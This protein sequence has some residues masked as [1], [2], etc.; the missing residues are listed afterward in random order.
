MKK[1]VY[2][3]IAAM[4]ILA[5]TIVYVTSVNGAPK[6]ETKAADWSYGDVFVTSCHHEQSGMMKVK[7]ITLGGIEIPPPAQNSHGLPLVIRTPGGYVYATG[8]IDNSEHAEQYGSWSVTPRRV[9]AEG[10]LGKRYGYVEHV[11][12]ENL[13]RRTCVEDRFGTMLACSGSGRAL[14]IARERGLTYVIFGDRQFGPFD[15]IVGPPKLVEVDGEKVPQF[16]FA[17]QQRKDRVFRVTGDNRE[18][19]PWPETGK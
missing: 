2:T 18:H 11:T 7:S 13:D 17:E 6:C 14:Y 3:G 1:L 15:G 12:T 5:V 9:F 8:D 4:A 19:I 16:I 10:K